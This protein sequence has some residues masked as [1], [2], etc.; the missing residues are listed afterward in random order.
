[1]HV[2]EIMSIGQQ[3]LLV[4][5]LVAAPLLVAGLV[6]GLV[7]SILQAATQI[8]ELTLSFIPK[9][10]VMGVVLLLAG[11]WMLHILMDFTANLVRSIP[12]VISG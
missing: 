9:I 11:S 10:F 4:T 12:G 3:A 1:M 6:A 8:N 2:S 5:M 7:I